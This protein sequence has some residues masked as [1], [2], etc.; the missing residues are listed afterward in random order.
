V[1]EPDRWTDRLE[2]ALLQVDDER[3]GF[4]APRIR[5]ARCEL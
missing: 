1:S 4:F 5:G 3:A 2:L